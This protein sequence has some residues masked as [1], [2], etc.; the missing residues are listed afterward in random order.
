MLLRFK[1]R[2][3][4]AAI[5]LAVVAIYSNSFRNSFHFDDFHSVVNN[6]YIRNLQ[7]LPRF[8]TDAT[9]F[10]VLPANQTYRPFVSASLA[11]DYALAHGYN[12]FWF[13]LS[14]F[15][16]FLCQLLA[17]Y[18]LFSAILRTA[19]PGEDSINAAKLAASLAVAWYGLHPAIAETV[20]YIIQRGDVYC[21]FGVS[22]SLALFIRFPRWRPFGIYLLPFAFAMLSKPPAAV[23]PVL[24]FAYVAMFEGDTHHGIG[25]AAKSASPSVALCA[26]LIGLQSAMTPKTFTQSTL[27]SFSYWITQ[28]FVL[29]RYFCS[30]F[31]PVHLNVD[32][33]L[34]PF[35]TLTPL[36]LLGF[37]FITALLTLA[38]ITARTRRW[39]PTSF[40]LLWFLIASLPTSVYRLS[41]VEN[42]H[43][44]YMPFIGL[45][46]AVIWAAFL[47]V[48][49]VAL[50]ANGRIVWSTA[51][52]G[53][54]ILL[55][56]YAYGTR[57]RNRVWHTDA[58]LWL[59]DVQ[60]CPHNGRGLMNY[61]LTR[62]AVGD[63][64]E[65][66]DYFQRALVYT[67]NYKTL[68]IN[69]GVV[70]GGL[71]RD[72]EAEQHFQRAIALD[73]TDDASRYYYGRWL[74]QR[75]RTADALPQLETAVRLNRAYLPARNLLAQ[76][77]VAV[78]D[79]KDARSTTEQTLQL[80][81]DNSEASQLVE[82]PTPPDANFWIEASLY[83]YRRGNYQGCIDDAKQ[84]LKLNPDSALAYNNIGAAYAGLQQWDA[85]IQSE[86]EALRIQP[87]LIIAKNNLLLYNRN[88]HSL[89]SPKHSAEDWLN[90]SLGDYQSGQFEKSIQDARAAL[91]LRPDYPEAYNN[92]AADYAS[93]HEW[94]QAISA[95]ETAVRM[96]PDFQLAKNNLAWAQSE[97]MKSLVR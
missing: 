84:A 30:F 59:D 24:L 60:K 18:V 13:H 96:K 48:R 26:V 55:A 11:V 52:L 27:S 72:A 31:L 81:P 69:L 71:N 91:K 12:V 85:A 45:A 64:P 75:G 44:M 46:L 36:A 67:P 34:Q 37:L 22:A 35:N 54:L 38:Y 1:H 28:P 3:L 68:E 21:A 23:F 95:A 82:H 15:V 32:T 17:M 6:P 8:F 29:L 39:R 57:L 86:H 4:L 80:A 93:M 65:A 89:P 92:I 16:V 9:T 61:G 43:R 49:N 53:A 20:N 33:D 77:Y 14:T 78:N 97:K 56:L 66:L 41:E 50:R 94:D 47:A 51:A 83:Q 25:T 42:D 87:D 70:Y 62:M 40:G 5:L 58:S 73:P 19:Y 74:F 7:N 10:S 2:F 79:L 88:A 90:A 63:Y 76:S